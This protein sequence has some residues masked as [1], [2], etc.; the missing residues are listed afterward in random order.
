MTR[1]EIFTKVR[2]I[3]ADALAADEEDVTLQATL[4]G[5][6][7]AES[8]DFLDI[9]FKLEQVFGIKIGQGELFAEGAANDPKFVKDGKVTGEGIAAMKARLPHVDFSAFEKDPSVANVKN[10]FT[11]STL[12]SFVESKLKK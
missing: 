11:V 6:L 9:Q 10:L 5:D 12:V 8:I 2:D 1:D 4:V 7:G 3:L